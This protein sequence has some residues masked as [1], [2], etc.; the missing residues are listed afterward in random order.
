MAYAVDP[1]QDQQNQQPGNASAQGVA[2]VTTSSA[3]GAGP[4]GAKTPTGAPTS[5]QAAQPFT[6]LQTYLTANAPQ[7]SQQANTISGNL[8][9]Q[10][11][12]VN[13]DISAGSTAFQNQVSAGFTPENSQVVQNAA[14]NPT[15]F[16]TD[17]NNV[18]AFQSQINDQYTG[19]ANFEGT[20]GYAGLNDEVTKDSANANLVNTPAGLQTYLQ[21]TETN[22]T[23]GENLL[24]S[25][26]LQQSPAAIQQV[27]Q[28][29]APFSQLPTYLSNN[30]TADDALASAAPGAAQQAATDAQ[31]AFTGTGGVV[32]TWEQGLQNTLATDTAQSNAY[33]T[34]VNNLIGSESNAN[35][36]LS[37][38]M[39]ALSTYNGSAQGYSETNPY[40]NATSTLPQIN[41]I[42]L[43]NFTNP[44]TVAPPTQNSVAS[45]GDV[46]EQ[47]ALQQLLGSGFNPF[48]TDTSRAGTYTTP[49]PSSV[50]TLNSYLAPQIATLGTDL[51]NA[52]SAYTANGVL[53]PN[54][55]PANSIVSATDIPTSDVFV[56]ETSNPY[57]IPGNHFS[58]TFNSDSIPGEKSY[59]P[60]AGAGNIIT[61]EQYSSLPSYI[62]AALPETAGGGNVA[63]NQPTHG[64]PGGYIATPATYTNNSKD[65]NSLQSAYQT[66]QQYLASQGG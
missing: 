45:S 24:D 5:A 61:P 25:V 26:L 9:N 54:G 37:A 36:D 39:D 28:A 62:Q 50:P 3:P 7:I 40:Y 48:L 34:A 17:P 43:Q 41:G 52:N 33:N 10:Y 4:S 46:A 30:V 2:P 29:A 49:D 6:N 13:N 23:Q 64:G 55:T 56:P 21:G 18:K 20:A 44:N 27:Q 8:T 60:G 14:A 47:A 19:P 12:Q 11:G 59:D 63:F 57:T 35:P 16:V 66:L 58:Q 65:L 31:A 22:P 32:P 1:T 15:Q 51:A 42:N 38:V 53:A